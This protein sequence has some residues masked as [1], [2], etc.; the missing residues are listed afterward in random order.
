MANVGPLEQASTSRNIT[1]LYQ[2]IQQDSSILEGIDAMLEQA[3]ISGNKL[4]P[5]IKQNPSI[6]EEINATVE[7]AATFRNINLLYL[8]IQ[9]NRNILEKINAMLQQD[10]TSKNMNMLYIAIQ[11]NPSILEEVNTLL[12]HVATYRNINLLYQAIQRDPSI[13]H[14]VDAM[15]ELATTSENT[16]MFYQAIQQNPYILEVVIAMRGIAT[17]GN[18]SM[19]SQAIE[20][21]RSIQEEV[22]VMLKQAVTSTNMNML[23]RAIQQNPSILEEVDA[24]LE[25][26]AT[27]KDI[28]MFYRTI[29]HNPN[30]LQVVNAMLVLVRA[31]TSGNINMLYRAIQQNP[32]ILEEVD[33]IPFVNTPLHIAASAGHV[34][35]AIEIMG[36]KPSFGFKLNPQGLSPI[37]VALHNNHYSLVDRLVEINKDLVRVKG[38]ERLTPLHLLCLSGSEENIRLLTHFL[39]ICPDSIKDVNVRKETALHIALRCGNLSALEKLVD[40]LK[41]NTFN[42]ADDSERSIL[43]SRTVDGNNILHLATLCGNTQCVVYWT[44]NTQ[45]VTLL[46]GSKK[47]EK[48]AKNSWNQTALDLAIANSYPEIERI[49]EGAKAKRGEATNHG[50]RHPNLMKAVLVFQRKKWRR[51]RNSMSSEQRDAYMVVAALIITSIYQTALSPPG[52]LYQPDNNL[53]P[54]TSSFSL[55]STNTATVHRIPGIASMEP[56]DFIVLSVINTVILFLATIIIFIVMPNGIIG[57]ILGP[58]L[59]LLV[60]TYAW[61]IDMISPTGEGYS[62]YALIVIA[63]LLYLISFGSL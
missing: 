42:S 26:A 34:E 37:H 2:A 16:N 23:Y 50:G 27:C 12:E 14:V 18:I 44:S 31:A 56:F 35:F 17:F 32:N 55:N 19:L 47:M 53:N 24:M 15:Y 40:W 48:N 30:N 20:Q 9:Q 39:H 52:G 49:L 5:A 11:Q 45:A 13:L 6:L 61:S 7:Q 41:E 59:T 33:A 10:T 63:L 3:A 51:L 4:H 60:I 36:L 28:N 38:K 54:T 62:S 8:A 1:T 43:N 25:Q 57:Y 22:N 46:I 21:D 29:Q 58:L